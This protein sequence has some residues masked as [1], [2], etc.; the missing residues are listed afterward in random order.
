MLGK[1][2]IKKKTR[3]DKHKSLQFYSS[4]LVGALKILYFIMTRRQIPLDEM[5]L[6]AVMQHTQE[7][8]Q[9]SGSQIVISQ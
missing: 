5:N 4:C 9:I 7:V 1:K 3:S 6:Q 8:E 2:Y